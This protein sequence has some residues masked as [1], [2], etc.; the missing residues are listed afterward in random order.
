M[1]ESMSIKFQIY[2]ASHVTSFNQSE[3]INSSRSRYLMT[4]TLGSKLLHV[5]T[6]I[7]IIKIALFWSLTENKFQNIHFH[8][9]SWS[10]TLLSNEQQ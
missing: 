10:Q 1:L 2:S 9:I 3:C 6:N 7:L 4:S 5:L 8:L